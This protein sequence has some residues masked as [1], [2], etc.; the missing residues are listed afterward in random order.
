MSALVAV[1]EDLADPAPA[2]PAPDW[3]D[4]SC[5]QSD[6]EAWFPE[7]GGSRRDPKRVCAR[8]PVLAGCGAWAVATRQQHGI[9][10][11]LTPDERREL[12]RVPVEVGRA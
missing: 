7:N 8:C 10:G 5:A 1:L 12:W 11:G 2:L 3:S 4:A 6:P 9:W